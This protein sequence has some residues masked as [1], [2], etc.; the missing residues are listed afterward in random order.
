MSE[1]DERYDVDAG[2][3]K[4]LGA[5][6]AVGPTESE[7]GVAVVEHTLAPGKL[8]APMHRHE[9]EDEI[10]YVLEGVMGV[11]EDD[12]VSTVEAGE[13]AVKERGVWHTFWNPGPEELRFL[14]IVAPGEFAGYFEET[15]AV[16]PEDGVPDEET[17]ARLEELNAAYDLEMD[18]A[19]VPELLERHDLEP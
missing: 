10:S 3:R 2:L 9:N 5:A 18:P 19:S 16:L 1:D 4:N 14:E 13:A 11:R 15:A 17:I 8:A 7:S 12:E 6:L